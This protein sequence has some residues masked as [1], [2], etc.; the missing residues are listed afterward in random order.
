MPCSNPRAGEHCGFLLWRNEM[1]PD[2]MVL[3]VTGSRLLDRSWDKLAIEL[4]NRHAVHWLQA[5]VLVLS[6]CSW[7]DVGVRSKPGFCSLAVAPAGPWQVSVC[8]AG[9]GKRQKQVAVAESRGCDLLL[10]PISPSTYNA[11][12]APPSA[13][14]GTETLAHQGNEQAKR[15]ATVPVRTMG[16]MPWVEEASQ[17]HGAWVPPPQLAHSQ[18]TRLQ[19][20][21]TPCEQNVRDSARDAPSQE[22]PHRAAEVTAR[23]RQPS[24]QRPRRT[25]SSQGTC[26]QAETPTASPVSTAAERRVIGYENCPRLL[27]AANCKHSCIPLGG[28]W[29]ADRRLPGCHAMELRARGSAWW[30][31][32]PQDP[33]R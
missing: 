26:C 28:I 33:Q 22:M 29:W 12:A 18:R 3:G 30:P 9:I 17:D 1:P 19:A 31:L 27:V 6:P 16:T 15:E 32:L 24:L 23:C 13:A 4:S 20:R 5:T 8:R 10:P 25:L 2:K 21:I 11:H 14:R 7:R